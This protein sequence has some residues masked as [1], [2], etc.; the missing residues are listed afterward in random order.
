MA[1]L[2][3]AQRELD[4]VQADTASAR[5]ATVKATEEA[6]TAAAEVGGGREGSHLA[7]A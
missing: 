2:A 7:Q 3:E 6:A 5:E 4:E 1:I